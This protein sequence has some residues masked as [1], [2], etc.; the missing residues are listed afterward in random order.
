MVIGRLTKGFGT[1]WYTDEGDLIENEQLV[2]ML[3][4]VPAGVTIDFSQDV[5][6][7]DEPDEMDMLH[8]VEEDE[9]DRSVNKSKRV[10]KRVPR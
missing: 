2:E 4:Q 8:E 6:A 7:D 3:D 10:G 5:E 9:I 1:D